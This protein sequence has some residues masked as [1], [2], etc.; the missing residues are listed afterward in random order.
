MVQEPVEAL[1]TI[2][3]CGH[4]NLSH[5]DRAIGSV[6]AAV[7]P[8]M[9]KNDFYGVWVDEPVPC[10]CPAWRPTE[11]VCD[12]ATAHNARLYQEELDRQRSETEEAPSQ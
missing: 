10:S 8:R 5:G 3:E 12:S 11:S 1:R 4:P 9:K 6:C 7:L 2:C